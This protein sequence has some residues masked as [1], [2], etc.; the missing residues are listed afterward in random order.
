MMGLALAPQ[1][2]YARTRCPQPVNPS[3]AGRR[4][5]ARQGPAHHPPWSASSRWSTRRPAPWCCLGIRGRC[6]LAPGR[7]CVLGA[8]RHRPPPVGAADRTRASSSSTLRCRAQPAW[9]PAAGT[10]KSQTCARTAV[11]GELQIAPRTPLLP[12]SPQHTCSLDTFYHRRLSEAH[13]ARPT[14][15]GRDSKTRRPP[16]Q[17]QQQQQDGRR[18]ARKSASGVPLSGLQ[19]WQS[20]W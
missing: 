10:T 19:L 5:E 11:V 13:A 7:R 4:G 1:R 15:R 12:T 2:A 6:G 20:A 3:G 8:R 14:T 18:A 9:P 16:A 17:R